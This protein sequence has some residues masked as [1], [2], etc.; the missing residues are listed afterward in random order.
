MCYIIADVAESG[1]QVY[2]HDVRGDE[3]IWN[4]KPR[5]Y[6]S[7]E[8]AEEVMHLLTRL[9]IMHKRKDFHL[10]VLHVD[11]AHNDRHEIMTYVQVG[12]GV[13]FFEE[14]L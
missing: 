4:L 7:F 13:F 5:P 8:V 9:R 10:R 1:S 11:H 2:L 6:P 12:E 14:D 3:A